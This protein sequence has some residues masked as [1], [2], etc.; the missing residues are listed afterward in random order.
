MKTSKEKGG[1][2]GKES[3]RTRAAA[4]HHLVVAQLV[5]RDE[6][7]LGPEAL[8]RLLEELHRIRSST[9][10]L[11]VPEDHPLR[12]DVL[13]DET[14]DRW[15][16]GS[17]L[18]GSYP[19][20]KPASGTFISDTGARYNDMKNLGGCGGRGAA[21]QFRLWMHVDKAAPMP[22]PV[23]TRIPFLNMAEA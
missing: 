17:F 14:R 5:G 13:V 16:K 7:D 9:L 21:Y 8:P 10:L 6:D 19:D 12:L 20:E 18:I 23:Q 11:R 4:L 15:P 2:G 1:D 3:Q 22:V